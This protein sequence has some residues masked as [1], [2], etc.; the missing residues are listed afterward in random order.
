MNS[1]IGWGLFVISMALLCATAKGATETIDGVTW[2][3]ELKGGTSRI[4][5]NNNK[6]ISGS[7]RGNLTIPETLGGK[8]V[9]C[10][11]KYAFKDCVGVTGVAIPNSVTNIEAY[12]FSGCS[13]IKSI[14][15]PD[16]V[17]IVAANA[18]NG[19]SGIRQVVIPQCVST[20][21]L[22]RIFPDAY[23]SMTNIVI[24]DSATSIGAATF[25]GCR[26][27]THLEIPSGVTNIGKDAFSGCT[28]LVE[29]LLPSSL[30][31][32]ENYLL[33]GCSSLTNVSLPAFCTNIG[34]GAFKGC[35]S[36]PSVVIPNTVTNIGG[37]A[38]QDCS[39]LIN[40]VIP[41]GVKTIGEDAFYSCRS[42]TDVVIPDSVTSIGREAFG[43]SGLNSVAI[44]D[45]VKA[46][47][48]V[49]FH[50]CLNLTNVT[51]GS[52]LTSMPN[53]PQVFSYCEN[54]IEISVDADNPAFSSRGGLLC[55]KNGT[56]VLCC[57]GGLDEVVFPDTATSIGKWAF[58]HCTKLKYISLPK[59]MTYIGELAF[60][61]CTNLAYVTI[62]KSVT[63]INQYAFYNCSGMTNVYFDS[64]APAIEEGAFSKANP[65][66][67]VLVSKGTTGWGVEIPGEWMGMNIQY[68]APRPYVIEDGVLVSV[69]IGTNTAFTVPEGVTRIADGAFAEC[70][71]LER[72]VIPDSVTGIARSAF[73]ECGKLWA[74]WYKAMASGVSGMESVSLTVTNVVVHYVTTSLQSDAVTPP[75]TTG[76]VN[77]IAEVMSGGPVA[78]A[79]TW[80]EQYPGFEA[81]FGSDFTAALTKPTGKHDGAGN[82]MFVWQDYVAGTDPT[83]PNDVFKASIT[84]DKDTGEPI[85]SWT[86]ELSA[87]EA[88]KRLYRK[89]GKVKLNDGDWTPIDGDASDY[90]FFKVTVEMR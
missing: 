88:A 13:G 44:P 53:C 21:S 12:S 19:C 39:A 8:P 64:N 52:G 2:Y 84:F 71:D 76:L 45:S 54:L 34:D 38:F 57:P 40:L 42:L 65:N 41:Y 16:T 55:D 30:T 90:N 75:E 26:G 43:N 22:S 32:I 49:A 47:G 35:G 10:I 58:E 61:G 77:V 28:N 66:C 80:S 73:D 7:P 9:V 17:Q 72:V 14:T 79:A 33:S 63:R 23:G 69:D 46:I 85:I 82:A 86:P 70:A 62:P 37:F 60:A 51:I 74:N 4:F 3:Y 59:T 27:L 81:K 25:A 48:F 18:F 1:R 29:I 31:C 83:N 6:A 20:N 89:Y 15:I 36:L 78:I 24:S 50:G 5:Y 67:V 87:Q 11:G 68:R 56:Q